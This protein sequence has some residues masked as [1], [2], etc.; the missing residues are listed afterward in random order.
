MNLELHRAPQALGFVFA[1]KPEPAN[2]TIRAVG[3]EPDPT[4]I[5]GRRLIDGRH[6]FGACRRAGYSTLPAMDIAPRLALDRGRW[7]AGDP[8]IGV[9]VVASNCESRPAYP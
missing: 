9:R 5:A 4:L 1:N 2:I 6:R 7:P 8:A 3:E